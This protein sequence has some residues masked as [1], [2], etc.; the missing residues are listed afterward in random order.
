MSNTPFCIRM[1]KLFDEKQT[2]YAQL[3]L[4][5]QPVK[6][7]V[8]NTENYSDYIGEFLKNKPQNLQSMILGGGGGGNVCLKKKQEPRSNSKLQ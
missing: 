3:Q 4:N 1:K 2:I 7:H 5:V 6:S 8:L